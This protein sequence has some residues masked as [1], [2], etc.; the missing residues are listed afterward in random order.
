[1]ERIRIVA[2]IMCALLAIA[3]ARPARAQCDTVPPNLT[4]FNFSP[5]SVDTTTSSQNVTCNMTLGDA[6]S[7]VASARCQLRFMINPSQARHAYFCT[8]TA[9]TAGVYSCVVTLPRYA[10]AGDGQ[11]KVW[12]DSTDNVGNTRLWKDTDL[13]SQGFPTDLAVTSDPDVVYPDITALS[14]TPTA[15]DVSTGA[16]TLTC[17]MT[18]TDAKSGVAEAR[19]FL[20]IGNAYYDY[21]DSSTPQSG[22]R[23]NGVFE[24]AITMPQ[25]A[26]AGVWAAEVTLRDVVGNA[27]QF[28]AAALQSKGL[29]VDV[30]VT[31]NPEDGEG[32]IETNFDFNPKTVAAGAGPTTITCSFEFIDSPAGV[33]SSACDFFFEDNSTSPPVYQRQGCTATAL[34]SGTRQSGTMSCTFVVP[35]YSAPGA[36][37]DTTTYTDAIGTSS[38]YYPTTPLTVGCSGVADPE[39]NLQWSDKTTLTWNAI[40]GATRYNVY[41]GD[42]ASLA[43]IYGLCQNSRDANLTDLQ[44]LEAQDPSPAGQAFNFLVSYTNGGLEKGLGKRSNGTPRTVNSPC[45]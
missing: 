27:V 7:G 13:A 37:F 22:T 1:M 28:D 23:Q 25:Y 19:C 43:T 45:P 41:R 39:C 3:S 10:D 29:P 20:N 44:F 21:C 31:S 32:P 42:L 6:T 38:D 15:V 12:V 17:T 16:R 34:A 14:I 30:T 33:S 18:L 35:R 8:T 2:G 9:G 4:A 11:W 5:T 40:A 36:W 24:C 26:A